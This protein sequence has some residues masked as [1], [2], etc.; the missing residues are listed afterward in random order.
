[1][2][3]NRK[4]VVTTI[5]D[6][7]RKLLD[8]DATKILG[9]RYIDIITEMGFKEEIRDIIDE[10]SRKSLSVIEKN[11]A[12]KFGNKDLHLKVNISLLKTLEKRYM[13]VVVVF[14]DLSE[15]QK[16][17]RIAAWREVARRIAHEIKNPLTPI[18]LSA[19][20][21]NKRYIERFNENPEDRQIFSNCTGM[22]INQVDGIKRMVN[23]FASFARMPASNPVLTSL[24]RIIREVI[25]IYRQNSNQV[26]IEYHNFSTIDNMLLDCDQIKRVFINLL[27]NSITALEDTSDPEIRIIVSNNEILEIVSIEVIDNGPGIQP[28]VMDQL[29]EPYFSTRGGRGGTGLGLT[30]A[31]QIITDHSGYI[32]ASMTNE[33][34]ARFLIEIPGIRY[35]G[36]VIK[37]K[38]EGKKVVV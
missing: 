26:N 8:V 11:I 25:Q 13:G 18:Q 32:R 7:A 36:P 9:R 29:F 16:S 38:K 6:Y 5:N 10:M 24:D 35:P 37:G 21:L 15:L 1:M 30:I 31:K 12:G 4:G 19:Q 22:I 14:D 34:G 33:K 27:D 17:H 20:R 28:E 3:L 2:A 23:E